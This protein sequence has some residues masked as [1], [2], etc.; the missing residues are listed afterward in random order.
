[1]PGE[2]RGRE[3]VRVQSGAAQSLKCLEM[4]KSRCGIGN[5]IYGRELRGVSGLEI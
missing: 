2:E 1:M 4:A 5:S 3:A